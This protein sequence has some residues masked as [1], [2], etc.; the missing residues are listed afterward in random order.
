M[1][2]PRPRCPRNIRRLNTDN[3]PMYGRGNRIGVI[4]STTTIKADCRRPYATR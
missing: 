1:T 2:V 4:L 3:A